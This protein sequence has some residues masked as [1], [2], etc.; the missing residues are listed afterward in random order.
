M[1]LAVFERILGEVR[2]ELADFEP[3]VIATGDA[4]KLLDVFAAIERSMVAATTLVAGRAA[5]AGLWREEGHRSPASWLA[6]KRGTGVGEAVGTLESSERLGGLPETTEA[7]RRGELSGPQLKVITAAAAEN[8]KAEKEL[9]DAAKRRSLK[10]LQEECLRV[11]A[12]AGSEDDARDRYERIRKNRSLHMWTDQDGVGRLEAKLPPDD[13]ARVESA[14]RAGSNVICNEARKAGQREP[15][16]AYDADALVA[17]VTGSSL[18]P[19]RVQGRGRGESRR[20]TTMM[21]LRVD[22]AALK[23]GRR[24]G[25]EV[26]EIPGV[27]P[28][29]VATAASAVGDAILKVIISDGVDVRGVCHLGRAVPAHVRS[30]L[31]DRDEKCVVPGCDVAKGLEIDHYK[32]AFEHGGA[33]ELWNLCRLCRWHHYLKTHCHFR[34]SGEPGSWEWHAPF[35]A[36]NP[37]LR[38]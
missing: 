23:R 33:T 29:P 16:V 7:L 31:E 27:G 13:F 8:P 36:E 14:I 21:H 18:A 2:G 28:V 6:Q 5:E 35:D 20:A 24:R 32:V 34:I 26:C 12:K 10:G 9:I 30:A 19:E 1:K 17:L 11:K 37:V 22:L 38:N 3:A 4:A 25:D 15:T